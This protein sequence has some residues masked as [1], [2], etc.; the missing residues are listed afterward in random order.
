MVSTQCYFECEHN[1][2]QMIGYS[3]CSLHWI[4]L[5]L[6]NLIEMRR[7]GVVLDINKRIVNIKTKKF[8]FFS[9]CHQQCSA[10]IYDHVHFSKIHVQYRRPRQTPKY[11]APVWSKYGWITK[12]EPLEVIPNRTCTRKI[13]RVSFKNICFA[14]NLSKI[15]RFHWRSASKG[16]HLPRNE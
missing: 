16:V 2:C 6:L 3:K 15:K 12:Y 10:A 5:S 13:N 7:N 11:A 1:Q 4:Y 14:W 8:V 9:C